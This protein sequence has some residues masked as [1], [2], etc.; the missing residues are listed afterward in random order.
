MA[1]RRVN[2]STLQDFIDSQQLPDISEEFCKGLCNQVV[3]DRKIKTTA[4]KSY[5]PSGFGGCIRA[6]YYKRIGEPL[7][8]RNETY[9]SVRIKECGDSSH[10]K[11][12]HH[13]SNMNGWQWVNITEYIKCYHLDYLQVLTVKSNGETLLKDTRYDIV[14]CVDGLINRNGFYYL[15]EIKTETDDKLFHR[16]EPEFRH[17]QQVSCYSMSLKVNGCVFLY[18]GR[19]YCTTK[20]FFVNITD[21]MKNDIINQINEVENCVQQKIVPAES[22]SKDS[23]MYCD[24][25][26]SCRRDCNGNTTQGI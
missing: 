26:N 13:I 3:T 24:Y 15:L 17:I 5:T 6:L 14:F 9:S 21:D 10:M 8:L 16:K 7:T 22:E 11:L 1:F 19:N 12:Q 2:I 23:C 20:V 4:S 25:I 18:E